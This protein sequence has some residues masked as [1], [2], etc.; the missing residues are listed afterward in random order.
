MVYCFFCDIALHDM[1]NVII[2]KLVNQSYKLCFM[3][4]TLISMTFVRL[5][6]CINSEFVS[7]QLF[8]S[9]CFVLYTTEAIPLTKSSI[10]ML[11]D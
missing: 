3:R 9:Y 11:D 8:K 4:I 6:V 10:K 2:K 1:Y 7:V 5:F